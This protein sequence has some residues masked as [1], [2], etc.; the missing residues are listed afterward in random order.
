[1]TFSESINFR[2]NAVSISH[3]RCLSL[4]ERHHINAFMS[5]NLFQSHTW[6]AYRWSPHRNMRSVVP[7][8]K[9]SISHLRCLSLIGLSDW[10]IAG[11]R[12]WR[13]NLT[14]EMLI[15]DRWQKR[16]TDEGAVRVSISH[17]RCLSLIVLISETLSGDKSKFQSHTWDAYRWSKQSQNRHPHQKWSFNLTLEMLIVD[18]ISNAVD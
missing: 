7:T 17:L 6:D 10:R 11:A 13:F 9:V 5:P 12:C 16:D 3:L 14:L 15:V 4:I 2:A 8:Q 18:R 1:M